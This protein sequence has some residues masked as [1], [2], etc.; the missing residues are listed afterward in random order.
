[1]GRGDRLADAAL[2]WLGTPYRHNAKIRGVG[3]D[4]ARFV[5]G[6]CEDAGLIDRDSLVL[7]DFSNEWAL[8]HSRDVMREVA[9]RYC[10]LV[11][12]ARRGDIFLYQYGRVASH[13]GIYLGCDRVIHAYIDVGVVISSVHD[14]IFFRKNGS[15]RLRYVYRLRGQ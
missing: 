6:A 13:A 7:G 10:F 9:E 12:E 1:M 8:H 4:C 3:V 2:M 14:S 11:H 15:S 5:I